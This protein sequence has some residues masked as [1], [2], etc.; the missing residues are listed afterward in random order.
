[1]PYI[2]LHMDKSYAGSEI[3]QELIDARKARG[4]SQQALGD[5]VGS[6][7]S[8]ISKIEQGKTDLRLSGLIALARA[9]DLEVAL[10]PKKSV[11]AVEAVVRQS[12]PSPNDRTAQALD[13]IERATKSIDRETIARFLANTAI[14]EETVRAL[15]ETLKRVQVFRYDTEQLRYLQQATKP[16][17]NLKKLLETSHYAEAVRQLAKSTEQLRFLRN[18]LAHPE[19]R[20]L[21]KPAYSLDEG[22]DA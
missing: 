1:V 15:N 4:L 6:P 9:L 22:D 17:E 5:R 10:V 13:V 21:P 18:A 16:I 8:H 20:S 2:E 19:V 3:I 7:Q 14:P 11:S 12:L